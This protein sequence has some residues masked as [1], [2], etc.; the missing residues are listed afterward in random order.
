MI[1]GTA[2]EPHE[3]A[4]S[5]RHADAAAH[6]LKGDALRTLQG[7]EGVLLAGAGSILGMP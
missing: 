5:A 6:D 7:A 2:I 3:L 1:A 4:Q